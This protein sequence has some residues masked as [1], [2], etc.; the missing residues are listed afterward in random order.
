MSVIILYGLLP[1]SL[2]FAKIP[3]WPGST[4][5]FLFWN[6]M[7]DIT[8]DATFGNERKTVRM[9]IPE[10]SGSKMWEVSINCYHQGRL[11]YRDG[12]WGSYLNDLSELTT[13]DIQIL[14]E[15]IEN[16]QP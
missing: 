11:Y 8:F 6:L 9:S 4:S 1:D 7:N 15:M 12:Q 14:G 5:L 13:A 2:T 10:G 3:N 16:A